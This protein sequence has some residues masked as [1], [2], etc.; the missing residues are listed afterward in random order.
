MDPAEIRIRGFLKLGYFLGPWEQRYPID[1]SRIDRRLYA[2]ESIERLVPL[3]IDSLDRTF[4]K[5]FDSKRENVVPL[6]GGLD[7]R[8]ILGALLQQTEASRIHTYT[9]G[10]PG[11]YDYELGC[12]V[13]KHAGTRH[14]AFPLDRIS[15]HED[16][17]TELARRTRMQGAFLYHPPLRE[18][19]RCYPGAVFWSGYVGDAIVGS[20]L[21]QRPARTADEAKRRYLHHRALVRSISL[22]ACDDEVFLPLIE[23]GEIDPAIMTFDEQVL[24]AEAVP[25]F[26]EPLVLIPPLE[27][28]TPLIN[29]PW[30]DFNFSVPDEHRR[31]QRLMIRIGQL[32]FPQLFALPAKNKLG[33]PLTARP[34]RVALQKQWNRLRKLIH[35]FLPAV[36]HPYVLYNDFDEGIR[37]SRDLQVL[38]RDCLTRLERRRVASWIDF[39]RIWTTHMRRMRN[40]G[41]ALVVLSSLEFNLAEDESTAR[42]FRPPDAA[43]FPVQNRA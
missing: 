27:Y 23:G 21:K 3:G 42:N 8:L 13:A 14:V 5:L 2:G 43:A 33:L 24:F 41:D 38:V 9:Y 22:H 4:A 6:S 10:V 36:S 20:H 37:K 26:T 39:D 17:L 35:Q 28:R 25:K 29:T 19:E 34:A 40:H 15:Y 12:L 32:A 16:E 1:F 31:G 11:S 30:M 18:I 7:S